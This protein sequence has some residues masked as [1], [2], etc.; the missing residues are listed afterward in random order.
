MSKTI[1]LGASTNPDR[2]SFQAVHRLK[3]KGEEVIP[4]GIKKGN[5]AD[6]PIINGRPEVKNVSTVTLYLNP[7]RQVDY[8]DYI[9]SLKPN[10]IIFR[11]IFFITF[12]YRI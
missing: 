10:R 7:Q 11:R 9:L 12:K 5:V 1:V 2:I 3:N 6:I 4:I 8:Y